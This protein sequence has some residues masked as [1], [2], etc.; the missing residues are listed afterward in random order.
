MSIDFKALVGSR[1]TLR[2]VANL[3]EA[4]NISL[5]FWS[6]FNPNTAN[7]GIKSALTKV[8]NAPVS[9]SWWEGFKADMANFFQKP[10]VQATLNT[11]D[12]PRNALFTQAAA[13]TDGSL[14]W[15]DLPGVG[16][17]KGLIGSYTPEGKVTTET[18]LNRAGIQGE[19][20][21][22]DWTDV[23]GFAGDVLLDPTTYL[24]LGAGSAA[25]A[26]AKAT[27]QA[28]KA[29]LKQGTKEFDDFVT[30]AAKA[31]ANNQAIGFNIPF[32]PE[33]TLAQKP[34]F[35][36]IKSQKVG[37]KPA[38]DLASKMASL[39]LTNQQRYD[40]ASKIFGRPI[41][42]FKELNT[43]EWDF[44]NNLANRSDF[45]EQIKK[46]QEAAPDPFKDPFV[47]ASDNVEVLGPKQ[48][49]SGQT[50]LPATTWDDVLFSGAQRLT[51]QSV[52]YGGASQRAAAGR[53]VV[54]ADFAEITPDQNMVDQL[55][56][57]FGGGYRYFEGADGMSD[58]GR[59]IKG[60][61]L[62]ESI[63][64]LI[65][66]RR[67]VAPSVQLADHRIKQGVDAI[68]DAR[69]G[70]FAKARAKVD[71]MEKLAKDPVFKG[72]TEE[73]L[74]LIPYLI[75]GKWPKSL[76]P[77]T[78]TPETMQKLQAAADKLI[79]YRDK[80]T[81]EE[82][83]AGVSYTPRD[84][85]FPHILDIPRDREEFDAL[86]ATLREVDPDLAMKLENAPRGF[87]RERKL[88]ESMADI[89]DFLDRHA[90]N[91]AIQERFGNAVFNPIQ[92]YARRA[93]SGAQEVAK[94]QS[95]RELE[96]LGIARKLK[97]GEQV[98]A[99]WKKID[100]HGLE[101]RVV[102]AEIYKRMENLNKIM[103]NDVSL[104]KVL[105]RAE[106]MYT[107]WRRNA[108]VVGPGFHIRQ[109]IGNIFQNTL[110]G[111]TPKAYMDAAKVLSGKGS[112][113]IGG[114]TKSAEDIIKMAMEDGIINTGSSTD[115]LNSLTK[116]LGARLDKGNFAQRW[117]N[118]LSEKFIPGQIGRKASEVEDNLS[119]L[120]HYI[121]VLQKGGSRKVARESVIKHLFDYSNL[122]NIERGVMRTLMPFYAWMRNNIPFQIAQAVKRPGLYQVID[123]LQ[124]LGQ[125]EPE[126]DP[127]LDEMGINRE[128]HRQIMRDLVEQNGGVLPE[129]I[130]ERYVNVGGDNYFNLSLPSSDLAMLSHPLD[131]ILQSLG[132]W[133][134]YP[135]GL[136]TNRNSFGAPIN[137]YGDEVD[138]PSGVRY[139]LDQLGGFPG[140]A[141]GM[142]LGNYFPNTV[143]QT[144]ANDHNWLGQIGR[145]I[146]VTQVDP[147]KSLEGI[148]Y[149]RAKQVDNE[150]KRQKALAGN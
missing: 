69:I 146:G 111:V 112:V 77:S 68:E 41:S 39:G 85:Y 93:M 106:Q 110:A 125:Q 113:K 97:P 138:L 26:S 91:P 48:L 140:R 22:L 149:E 20:G 32:G 75:E 43:Q 145:L 63:G 28:L 24:T 105:N 71:E 7:S 8:A 33:I 34:D 13:W 70:G 99:G 2:P 51:G 58:L 127:L 53:N 47:R 83:D 38:A 128:D 18:F 107:I 95:Y 132:P 23:A 142:L 55:A 59:I 1:P 119:R 40:L 92:A 96:R 134:Q 5:D 120:A 103:T 31:T 54:D 30:K 130:R 4:Q 66:G 133:F 135:S 67:Y 9:S 101:D 89:R 45:E 147:V 115:F 139:T 88:F 80:F 84:N 131:N 148:L 114:Q 118:P 123:D 72:L 21:K 29:G 94:Q 86:V 122:S 65:G 124:E 109:I 141:A 136:M 16:I 12:A 102:P 98:P 10:A 90:D 144:S 129:Y 50:N 44:L 126:V 57:M 11:L 150:R 56:E 17:A 74:K 25:K 104:N 62:A 27:Q 14:D 117:L 49:P 78:I 35:L 100:I 79:E 15:D 108:T 37:A 6:S 87:T 19:E 137:P 76:D 46:I 36:K 73:E 82:L 3:N 81:K 143:G 52:R 121:Y 42:S 60:S 61:N 116:E 64:N